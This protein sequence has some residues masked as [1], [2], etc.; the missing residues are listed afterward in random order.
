M[1]KIE[2]E[3]D[4]LVGYTL[5]GPEGNQVR[6]IGSTKLGCKKWSTDTPEELAEAAERANAIA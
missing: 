6:K 4:H 1:R 5:G 2:L 3:I